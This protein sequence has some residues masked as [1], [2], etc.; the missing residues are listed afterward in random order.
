MSFNI[1][2]F[3][4]KINRPLLLDGAMGSLLQQKG[5][6]SE[7]E[8]W[9][10]KANLKNP[11]VVYDIHLSYIKAGADIITTNTFRTNPVAVNSQSK[12]KFEKLVKAS[13]QLAKDAAKGQN[14]LIAG[15]NAP[16]EDCYQVERRISKKE[17]ERNHKRHIDELTKNEC[18]FVLNETQSHFDEIKI[19]CDYCYSKNVPFVI[20]LLVN[21]KL[22]LLS[23]ENILEVLKY[24]LNRSPLCIGF[25]CI[26]PK[27][28]RK[29]FFKLNLDYNWGMYLNL[30]GGKYHDKKFN[31]S[32]SPINYAKIITNYL[33]ERPSFVGGCCGSNPNHIKKLRQVLDGKLNN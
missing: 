14:V 8:L 21:E 3:A 32:L 15:S 33:N 9:T 23:G 4:R 31:T 22:T 18:D 26:T 1:F 16:A 7:G 11:E 12:I 2:T 13:V 29:I 28:F 6:K 25:N 30:G 10:A 24:L 20:S 27:V 19:I 5:I 17:L